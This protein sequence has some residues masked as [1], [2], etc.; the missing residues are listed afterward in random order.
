MLTKRK[1]SARRTC[2]LT[3]KA[4]VAKV[5]SKNL[6]RD[7]FRDVDDLSEVRNKKIKKKKGR[8]DEK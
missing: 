6:F 7:V 8:K 2:E 4:I 3:S 5:D 1:N